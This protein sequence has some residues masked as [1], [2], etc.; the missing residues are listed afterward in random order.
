MG[1]H[2]VDY[3]VGMCVLWDSILWIMWLGC[4]CVMG[5]HSV[6]S[7]HVSLNL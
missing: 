6:D 5:R 1:H 2:S 4:V 3:V 7:E